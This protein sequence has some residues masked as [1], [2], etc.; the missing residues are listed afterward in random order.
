M[1][2]I[3]I[4]PTG[5]PS[6]FYSTA[7]T[8]TKKRGYAFGEHYIPNTRNMFSNHNIYITSDEEIKEGDWVLDNKQRLSQVLGIDNKIGI[9]RSNILIY[10]I[11]VC[12]KIIL[13]TDQDL[14]AD[15]V[16]AIDD[17]FKELFEQAKEIEKQEKDEFAIDFYNWICSE[18]AVDLIQDLQIV[19]EL[20][21]IVTT[22]ELL[23][24]F[25]NK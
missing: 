14:I 10:V 8:L 4:L 12:K 20:N 1:K 6:R 25:K 5:K 24:I 2:N 21:K 9:L 19:G 22:E 16:Q 13:T 3:H 7:R 18:E 17:K 15:G 11:D 23:E